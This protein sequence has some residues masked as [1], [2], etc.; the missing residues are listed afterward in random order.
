MPHGEAL[1]LAAGHVSVPSIGNAILHMQKEPTN[2]Q[3]VIQAKLQLA[4]PSMH[5]HIHRQLRR[6][7]DWTP[8]GPLLLPTGYTP[9]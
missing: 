7:E 8:L 3:Y 9:V 4:L 6:L 1:A 5:S 2:R